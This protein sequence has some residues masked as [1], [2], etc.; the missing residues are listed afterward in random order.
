MIMKNRI[1]AAILLL[2]LA[3]SPGAF[4]EEIPKQG[5]YYMISRD[6][7]REFLGSHKI[8][9]REAPNLYKVTY[10]D[11]FYWVRA[12]TVAWTEVEVE[13]NRQVKVEFNFGKGWRPLCENP[14][15]Q[16]TLKDLGFSEEARVLLN[17][18]E[19]T[20][21]TRNR[22]SAISTAFQKTGNKGSSQGSFHTK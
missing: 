21:A 14:E 10:C 6:N 2:C 13:N 3:V 12:H 9:K 19:E 1:L 17:T 18:S 4:A 20:R 22:F 15:K 11:R 7:H 8:F 5:D 16:V